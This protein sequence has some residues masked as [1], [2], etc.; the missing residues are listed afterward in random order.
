VRD[1]V[2]KGIARRNEMG[3]VRKRILELQLANKTLENEI[4]ITY[5]NINSHYQETITSLV[6]CD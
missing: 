6:S 1:I 5:K 3:L 2:G 4:E